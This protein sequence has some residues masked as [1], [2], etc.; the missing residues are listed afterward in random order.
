[1]PKSHKYLYNYTTINEEQNLI[2]F[3]VAGV[4]N[5]QTVAEWLQQLEYISQVRYR[6]WKTY[7]PKKEGAYKV[8]FLLVL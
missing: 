3:R 7:K 4:T 1:L 5:R 8:A 2:E 6:V